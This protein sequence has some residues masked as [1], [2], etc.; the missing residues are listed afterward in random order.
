MLW[1]SPRPVTPLGCALA[2]KCACK[3]FGMRSY[4]F[5]GLKVLWNEQMRKRVGGGEVLSR[6]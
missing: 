4:K 6:L 1:W 2:E 3:C 5:I